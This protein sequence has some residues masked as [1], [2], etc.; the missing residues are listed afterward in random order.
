LLVV[1]FIHIRLPAPWPIKIFDQAKYVYRAFY[2]TAMVI[3]GETDVYK[4][5]IRLREVFRV[6]GTRTIKDY[7]PQGI[8][9]PG[10]GICNIRLESRQ[11]DPRTS[12]QRSAKNRLPHHRISAF[13]CMD[14]EDDT[15][16]NEF[17][18]MAILGGV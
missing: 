11:R 7:R 3:R 4:T 18:V 10:L 14:S 1:L 16:N 9:W 15:A 5:G 8:R 17:S 6:S 13:N 2:V 12:S